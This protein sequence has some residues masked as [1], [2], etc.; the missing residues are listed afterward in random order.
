VGQEESELIDM[1]RKSRLKNNIGS[2]IQRERL[3]KVTTALGQ[4]P[5]VVSVAGSM[6]SIVIPDRLPLSKDSLQGLTRILREKADE[7]SGAVGQNWYPVGGAWLTVEG[8]SPLVRL[9]KKEGVK[10]RDGDYRIAGIGY[11]S[12]DHYAGGYSVHFDY[13]RRTANEQQSLNYHTPMYQIA[14][15]VLARMGIRAGMHTYVD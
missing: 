5:V 3:Q 9:F 4:P 1:K 2:S 13:P 12:R 7:V 15:Q 6:V 10:E 11:I 8:N 14:Q